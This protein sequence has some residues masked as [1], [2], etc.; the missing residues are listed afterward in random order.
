MKN[1]RT[2]CSVFCSMTL[3]MHNYTIHVHTYTSSGFNPG[4]LPVFFFHRCQRCFPWNALFLNLA[5]CSLTQAAQ[6]PIATGSPGEHE[7][8]A[9]VLTSQTESTM[10]SGSSNVARTVRFQST[11]S[12]NARAQASLAEGQGLAWLYVVLFC[13]RVHIRIP[14]WKPT[15]HKHAAREPRATSIPCS[16]RRVASSLQTPPRRCSLERRSR[17]TRAASTSDNWFRRG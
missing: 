13:V 2:R 6:R 14:R 16:S 8:S 1:K 7:A 12:S 9:V 15:Q 4:F 5:S 11:V 10:A 17:S 3:Y